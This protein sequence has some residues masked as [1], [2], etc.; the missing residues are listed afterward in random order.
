MCIA[1]LTSSGGKPV[2]GAVDVPPLVVHWIQ[3]TLLW[4]KTASYFGIVTAVLWNNGKSFD[5]KRPHSET[6]F[7]RF[8][9][10]LPHFC[11]NLAALVSTSH[12]S[13]NKIS[14]SR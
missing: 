13:V 12:S 11:L 14:L 8:E 9:K 1:G 10:L 6:I 7:R 5:T 2:W 3:F 4:N